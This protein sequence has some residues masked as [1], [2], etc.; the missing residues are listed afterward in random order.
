MIREN[1]VLTHYYQSTERSLPVTVVFLVRKED[2][3]EEK[4]TITGHLKRNQLL[5]LLECSYTPGI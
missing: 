3:K 5:E 2:L 1:W 4:H